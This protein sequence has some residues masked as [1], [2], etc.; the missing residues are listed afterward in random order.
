[1]TTLDVFSDYD[2]WVRWRH[3]TRKLYFGCEAL[4]RNW[5]WLLDAK[6]AEGYNAYKCT[7][8]SGWHVGHTPQDG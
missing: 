8:C 1:M 7:F 4:A 2:T 6:F 3:C 5:A